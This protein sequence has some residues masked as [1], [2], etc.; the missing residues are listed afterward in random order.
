LKDANIEWAI[1]GHS[2]RRTLFGET[3]ETAATRCK[4]AVDNGVKVIYCIGETLD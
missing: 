4:F 2:E 1:V 3:D